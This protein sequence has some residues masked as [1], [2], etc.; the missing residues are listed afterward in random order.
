MRI[1]L[2]E[3]KKTLRNVRKEI[4]QLE[5]SMFY[6]EEKEKPTKKDLFQL[7]RYKQIKSALNSD[8]SNL[9]YSIEWMKT[10]RCPGSYKG[11]DHKK[12]YEQKS[13]PPSFFN[14]LAAENDVIP[15]EQNTIKSEALDFLLK[16]LNEVEKD[17]FTVMK[18]G[19][20][21]RDAEELLGM[22]KDT[23]SR[24]YKAAEAKVKKR[25]G[26]IRV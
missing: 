24:V 11:V 19:W 5:E 1:L 9:V 7:E 23:I 2:L 10:G 6:L 22:K 14:R 16:D 12:A 25:V 26:M 8:L 17:I 4:K 15:E 21:L 3:Y 13:F 20:S 18:L